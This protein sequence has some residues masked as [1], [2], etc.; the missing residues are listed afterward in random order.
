MGIGFYSR[1][2]QHMQN[3]ASFQSSWA[4][5][6]D[7]K[8]NDGNGSSRYMFFHNPAMSL[9]I[10][11]FYCIRFF[12]LV[13]GFIVFLD[14]TLVILLRSLYPYR[15]RVFYLLS[16]LNDIEV[17]CNQL[18]VA[19]IAFLL[20]QRERQLIGHQAVLCVLF[21]SLCWITA[22]FYACSRRFDHDV[23]QR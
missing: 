6:S 20:H 15:G 7:E 19:S 10:A 1:Q 14:I 2:W 12:R 21:P 9:K 13:M 8:I 5:S 4:F 3:A 11:I 16:G 17:V 23:V 22:L 18:Y